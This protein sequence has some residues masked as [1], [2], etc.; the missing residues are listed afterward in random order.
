MAFADNSDL[1]EWEYEWMDVKLFV[2]L[3]G[4][5]ALGGYTLGVIVRHLF[6]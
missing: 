1:I 2:L 6:V 4:Y 5:A 3:V